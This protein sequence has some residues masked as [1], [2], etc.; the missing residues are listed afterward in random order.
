M[1]SIPSLEAWS[2]QAAGCTGLA[3]LLLA[4][5][6]SLVT[7]VGSAG[8]LAALALSARAQSTARRRAAR[9][10]SA[11]LSEN[12][13]QARRHEADLRASFME[14]CE[15][16][17]PVWQRQLQ[18]ATR[19]I[20]AAVTA[21]AAD[22]ATI[23]AR[24]DAAG[25]AS[26]RAA[27]LDDAMG[28][29]TSL[30]GVLHQ[31]QQKLKRVSDL[32]NTAIEEKRH[33]LTGSR[34]LVEFTAE[35]RQ[36]AVDVSSIADQTNL[37]AL[38]AAIEAARAGDAGRGFAVVADEVRKL[39]TRSGE[40]G[41]H[42][43]A[44][45]EVIT[46]AIDE[47]SLRMDEAATR[48]AAS[49]S[50]VESEIRQVMASFE[51]TMNAL[52]TAASG[53]REENLAIRDAIH[54]ALVQLQFQDRVSQLIAHVGASVGSVGDE[55]RSAAHDA[56]PLDVARI[57]AALATSYTMQEERAAHAG[58]GNATAAPDEIQFF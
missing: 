53:L 39:S 22:F 58:D 25:V 13:R 37:L 40:I 56:R 9:E 17:L 16:T 8:V 14:L 27:G 31:G 29:E 3:A 47:S 24:L 44:K 6:D 5:G 30:G 36:M 4:Q 46:R 41:K 55:V 28:T 43:T 57:G 35:L 2:T 12:I 54:A 38:N 7:A 15:Q 26:L 51:S 49:R 48:D 52:S 42:I 21:L 11:W 10:R 23:V 19:Q 45:I 18:N 32:L 34:R 20:E 50:S 33:L 1:P